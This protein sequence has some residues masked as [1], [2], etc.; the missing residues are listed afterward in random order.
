MPVYV[1]PEIIEKRRIGRIRRNEHKLP[2]E[3]I[4]YESEFINE[5]CAKCN[6][7][8]LQRKI[9]IRYLFD[10]T[11]KETGIALGVPEVETRLILIDAINKIKK[12]YGLPPETRTYQKKSDYK[13]KFNF[14]ETMPDILESDWIETKFYYKKDKEAF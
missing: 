6:L 4:M 3:E 14:K 7:N 12:H 9:I 1:N 2:V 8:E 13:D 11:N 10:S 5:M